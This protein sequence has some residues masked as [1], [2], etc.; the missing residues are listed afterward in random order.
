MLCLSWLLVCL[1]SWL[2]LGWLLV[3]EL[4]C[5]MGGDVTL[6][7]TSASGAVFEVVLKRA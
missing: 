3:R 7:E 6:S 4:A 1:G 2:A 5:A